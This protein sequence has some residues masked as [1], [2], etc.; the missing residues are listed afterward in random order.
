MIFELLIKSNRGD[1]LKNIVKIIKT[2]FP[3][4]IPMSGFMDSPVLYNIFEDIYDTVTGKADEIYYTINHLFDN[5]GV[6]CVKVGNAALGVFDK[7]TNSAT[8]ILTADSDASIFSDFW[9]VV[10]PV[11]R[12]FCIIASTLMVLFFMSSLI[13]EAWE[14]RHEFEMFGF[15]KILLKLIVCVVI[16]NNAIPIV[17]GIF[18]AG[19]RMAQIVALR[20]GVSDPLKISSASSNYIAFG[21]SGFS[22][23]FVFLVYLIG[24]IVVISSAVIITLEIYQRVFKIYIL[25]P[26][27]CFSFSTFVLSNNGHGNEVF[28]GYLKSII[29]TS[30]EAVVIILALCFCSTLIRNDNTMNHL[31][32]GYDQTDSISITVNTQEE[33]RFAKHYCNIK[34]WAGNNEKAQEIMEDGWAGH[35]GEGLLYNSSDISNDFR[36]QVYSTFSGDLSHYE[37]DK[38]GRLTDDGNLDISYPSTYSLIPEVSWLDAFMILLQ[39]VFPCIL[40]AGAVKAADR[41]S[42]IIVGKG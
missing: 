19:A 14:S 3:K 41:Y 27:S 36:N 23:L 9:D 6:W 21:I 20:G 35:L 5:T 30:L 10:N 7:L 34:R 8:D 11:S 17:K 22:G 33:Y 28:H 2:F 12:V 1:D 24:S 32:N 15:F 37:V 42:G 26:F 38:I 25:I 29:Q 13:S 18:S 4:F 40:C 39:F 16:V 31:F